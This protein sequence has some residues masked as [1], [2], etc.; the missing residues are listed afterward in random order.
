ML[1]PA[2]G[3]FIEFLRLDRGSSERTLEAYR[4]DLEQLEDFLVHSTSSEAVPV[5]RLE[6]VGQEHLISFLIHLQQS[7][8]KASSIARRVSAMKQ[9]FKFCCLERGLEVNPTEQLQSPR[10]PRELPGHLTLEQV[11]A[12]LAAADEGLPYRQASEAPNTEAANRVETQISSSQLNPV[13]EAL[14]ARDRA[15]V[16]LLYATGLR[17]SELVG[18]TTH[19]VD[20]GQRYV[21]V[22]GKGDKER[23]SPFGANAGERIELY[24]NHHRPALDPVGDALFVNQRGQPLTRQGFWKLLKQLAAM[25]GVPESLSPHTLRHSFATHLLGAGMN[26]RSLQMLLGHSDLSTTQIYAHV[27][28]EHLK[29]AHRK[30]HPRGE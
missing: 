29:T 5:A 25:S 7:G 10:R 28:P 9:F 19:Q 26:L 21:R 20:L 2:L 6:D 4:C 8:Q 30:F 22:R 27:T 16:F 14:R 1:H 11:T 17:V 3:A 15:M 24:L 13:G 18:L 12:L 23:I